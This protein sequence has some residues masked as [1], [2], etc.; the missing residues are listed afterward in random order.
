MKP[1]TALQRQVVELSS[2]LPSITENHK[3]WS[4]EK[5]FLKWGVISRNKLNCLECAH[6]W[7]IE[8]KKEPKKIK[9]PNCNNILKIHGQNQVNFQEK[10]YFAILTT[11]KNFQVVRMICSRKFMKKGE[12]PTYYHSEVM[13][14]WINESGQVSTLAKSIQGFTM[15]YDRWIYFSEL[16]FKD[17]SQI[18]SKRFSINPWMIYP[19][20]KIL[21]VLKRN[22]FKTSFHDLAPQVLF[23]SLLTDYKAETLLKTGQINALKYYLV[24]HSRDVSNLWST[25]RICTK[26]NYVIKDFGNYYDYIQLLKHFGKDLHSPKYIC[27]ADLNQAHDKLVAKKREIEKREKLEN[28]KKKIAKSQKI[29]SKQ[30]KAFFGLQFSY[31]NITVKVIESVKDFLE[32]GDDLGHCVFTNEYYKKQNSLVL[33]A[34]VGD[35]RVETV[36]ILLSEMIINQSRGQKNK[37]TKYNSQI[38]DLVTKNLPKINAIYKQAS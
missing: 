38:V 7:K 22:G 28:M 32:E 37:A 25:V 13:Q 15:E 2:Q 21:P 33:S 11:V 23:T 35:K 6:I 26:N 12:V 17:S 18:G 24:S 19:E 5:I 8:S 34:M 20:R 16:T 36:E 27:P 14:H 4:S 31:K 30:K 9:C 10:E 3:N 1:K 29:Y